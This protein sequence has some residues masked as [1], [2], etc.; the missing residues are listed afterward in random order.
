MQPPDRRV[1]HAVVVVEHLAE[2]AALVVGDVPEGLRLGV[3][4]VVVGHGVQPGQPHRHE[5]RGPRRRFQHLEDPQVQAVGLHRRRV[6]A[7]IDVRGMG[8]AIGL[9]QH[10]VRIRVEAHAARR[11]DRRPHADR[12]DG[13]GTLER[14]PGVVDAVQDVADDVAAQR[15]SRMRE[16]PADQADAHPAVAEDLP[17]RHRRQR[18]GNVRL[19]AQE[20]VAHQRLRE[21][22]VGQHVERRSG[23]VRAR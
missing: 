21:D 18:L 23:R 16:R 19:L 4:Q 11:G 13:V 10:V 20:P 15:R 14:Q 22:V 7:H 2:A 3:A 8:E 1:E 6:G 12:R 5:P 9:G 17:Q